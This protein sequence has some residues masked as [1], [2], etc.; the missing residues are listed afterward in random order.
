MKKFIITYHAPSE[1]LERMQN[2][3]PE[4]SKEGMK[5]WM[6]WA[7]KCGDRLIDLGAPLVG[8]QKLNVNGTSSNSKRQV[9]GYS[10][11]QAENIEEAKELLKG[12]PHLS[13]WDNACEIEIHETMPM[14][15]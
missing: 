13:G 3:T 2:V 14:P 10:I 12:H 7:E 1:A 6:Q 15:V 8:G 5:L 9:C 11:L 4:E